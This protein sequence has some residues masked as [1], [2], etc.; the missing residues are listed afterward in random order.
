MEKTLYINVDIY[1]IGSATEPGIPGGTAVPEHA[2]DAEHG[3]L[4]HFLLLL[5]A[6]IV[7]SFIEVGD[8]SFLCLFLG[9]HCF[10]FSLPK[11]I[12]GRSESIQKKTLNETKEMHEAKHPPPPHPPSSKKT[13]AKKNSPDPKQKHKR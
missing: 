12:P 10:R 11:E 5:A 1:L 4:L 3:V 13:K 6:A 2:S 9:R 7:F 8:N